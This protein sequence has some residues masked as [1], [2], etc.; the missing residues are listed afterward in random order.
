MLP[1]APLRFEPHRVDHGNG[2]CVLITWD[3]GKTDKVEGFGSHSAAEAWIET[4]SD[5]WER[6]ARIT[7]T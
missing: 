6:A 3:D 4:E 7:R 1:L 2:W 5:S